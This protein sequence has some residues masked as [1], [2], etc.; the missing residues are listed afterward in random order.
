MTSP[1]QKKLFTALIHPCPWTGQIKYNNF[2]FV[3]WEGPA[4]HGPQ[5]ASTGN[6]CSATVAYDATTKRIFKIETRNFS[7]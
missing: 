6:M 5:P 1:M 7:G 4:M 2:R 3:G